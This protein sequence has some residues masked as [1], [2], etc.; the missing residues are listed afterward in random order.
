M[1]NQSS[2]C[3]TASER[4]AFSD[5]TDSEGSSTK[6]PS[7]HGNLMRSQ[8]KRD[9]MKCVRYS[10]LF[11]HVVLE[12]TVQ[13]Y[14]TLLTQFLML[15]SFFHKWIGIESVG[16]MKFSSFLGKVVWDRLQKLENVIR[17]SGGLLGPNS[18]TMRNAAFNSSPCSVSHN[19]ILPSLKTFPNTTTV[20]VQ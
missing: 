15:L 16:Y 9:P 4:T 11:A 12:Y 6:L 2:M 8:H 14:D 3:G 19:R 20:P 13:L 5:V 10:P 7:L 1:G 17:R 18:W